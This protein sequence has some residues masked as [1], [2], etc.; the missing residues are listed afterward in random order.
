MTLTFGLPEW[1]F[2]MVHPLIMENNCANLYWNPL[3]IVGDMVRTKIWFSSVTL[4][5]GLPE[6]MF[7]MAYLHVMENNCVKLFWNPST[8]V[9]VMV[10]TKS[11]GC[12]DRHTHIHQTVVVTNMPPSVQAGSTNMKDIMQISNYI[13]QN[14]KLCRSN[15]R[16]QSE[17]G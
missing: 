8:T 16:T 4:T 2:Q 17:R 6:Q 13:N 15:N 14:Q 10:G 3:K 12:M 11:D 9:E 7:Q 5:V 1:K